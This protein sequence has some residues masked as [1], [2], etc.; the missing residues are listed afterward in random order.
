MKDK[1]P[2]KKKR[3][4]K[5]IGILSIISTL[6]M[7]S[8]ALYNTMDIGD[9]SSGENG[10][11]SLSRIGPLYGTNGCE[12]GGFSIQIGTDENRYAVTSQTNSS[13]LESTFKTALGFVFSAI[14]K[15][16]TLLF[17]RVVRL[18]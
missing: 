6:I 13:Q 9:L 8:L 12:E 5:I 2:S 11:S 18:S 16:S 4:V 7:S 15:S 10:D 1:H 3:F 14:K 17:L